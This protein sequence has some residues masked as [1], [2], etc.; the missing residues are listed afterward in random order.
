MPKITGRKPV[1]LSFVASLLALS[2]CFEASS[3]TST[4]T[5][6][7]ISTP[8]PVSASQPSSN[9]SMN[10]ANTQRTGVYDTAPLRQSGSVSWKFK[11][12]NDRALSMPTIA[13]GTIYFGGSESDHTIYA[14]DAETGNEVWRYQT[15]F[16]GSSYSPIVADGTVYISNSDENLYA[17]D[18]ET[19][20]E[21]WRFSIQD[22]SLPWAVFDDPLV[23]G[24]V[25]YV[26]CTREA[27]YALDSKTGK[28]IWRFQASGWVDS[29]A[30][31]ADGTLYFGSRSLDWRDKTYVYAVDSQTGQ[32][33]WKVQV[34]LDGVTDTP[35]VAEGLVFVP[36]WREGL[37]ALDAVSGQQK[38]QYGAG[39]AILRSP[40]VAYSTVYVS[41]DGNLIALD[42]G[43]GQERWAF[44]T[45]S[46]GT[47][48]PPIIA[49]DVVYFLSTDIGFFI[50]FVTKPNAGGFLYAVNAHTG[51]ELWKHKV[52]GWLMDSPIVSNGVVYYGDE[53]GYLYAIR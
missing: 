52:K 13:D 50:P 42:N 49:G 19:G 5:A 15:S 51:Q 14:L 23:V 40:A 22:P 53:D 32:E 18:S 4:P 45:G 20:K 26:G 33:K 7:P 30:A 8:T 9:G 28:V 2:G 24:G 35:A 38:W 11:A 16:F 12:K 43:S 25:V 6:R 31:L 29:G 47:V 1:T 27:F 44:K 17:L 37:Y 46:S 36:T 41:K 21:L 10:R 3:N 39:S 34:E 48:T